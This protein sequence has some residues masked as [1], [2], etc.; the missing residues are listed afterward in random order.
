VTTMSDILARMKSEAERKVELTERFDALTPNQRDVLIY[1]MKGYSCPEIK[2]ITGILSPGCTKARALRRLGTPNLC[3]AAI[4]A[5]KAGLLG[6][7]EL[8]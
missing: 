3:A 7:G 1:A 5:Y 4:M 8:M 2:R 6:D